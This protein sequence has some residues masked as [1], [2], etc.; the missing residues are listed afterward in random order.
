MPFTPEVQAPRERA[1][2]EPAAGPPAWLNAPSTATVAPPAGAVAPPAGAVAAAAPGTP[3]PAPVAPT[4]T[5][6]PEKK[7]AGASF[8]SALQKPFTIFAKPKQPDAAAPAIPAPAI[9][10]PAAPAVAASGTAPTA[11]DPYGSMPLGLEGFCPVSL[12][13]KGTW[14]EGRAQWGARHRG[15]TYLF[16]GAEQQR[17][18]LADP[19]RYAPALSGDD[20]VLAC[21]SGRQV[22]GQRRFGVTYQARTY[23]FSSPE[24][25]AAFAANP[26]RY[27]TRVTIAERP[28]APGTAV[29]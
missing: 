14:V 9:P 13:D 24:T 2:I 25:R 19:D 15:R 10:A 7:S 26:Q 29:R 27:T 28:P 16:A 21:D 11:P 1:V 6:E 5:P 3:A 8:L 4:I 18:F 22:A 12:V 23:L 20:P 17:L